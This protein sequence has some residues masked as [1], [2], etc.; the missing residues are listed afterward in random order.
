[1]SFLLDSLNQLFEHHLIPFEASHRPRDLLLFVVR[2]HHWHRVHEPLEPRHE[3]FGSGD[4]LRQHVLQVLHLRLYC[5][6]AYRFL[7]REH[8]A[9][10]PASWRP[11]FLSLTSLL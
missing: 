10:L 6:L 8:L 11:T 9:T 2:R 7:L 4:S 5:G 3:L 1:M